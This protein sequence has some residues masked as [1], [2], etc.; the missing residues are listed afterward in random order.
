LNIKE[1]L[2]VAAAVVVLSGLKHYKSYSNLLRFN[3]YIIKVEVPVY[4]PQ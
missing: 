2:K 1:K 3:A 4:G